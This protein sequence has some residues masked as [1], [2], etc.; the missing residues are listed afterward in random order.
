MEW[1]RKYMSALGEDDAKVREKT[2]K[3]WPIVSEKNFKEK[4]SRSI[5]AGKHVPFL[6]CS[7]YSVGKLQK[8]RQTLSFIR[9][10]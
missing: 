1:N 9:T 8:L 10:A 4:S 5:Y 6:P 7:P 3:K 2:N